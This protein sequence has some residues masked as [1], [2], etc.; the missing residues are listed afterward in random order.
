MFLEF[1]SS[2]KGWFTNISHQEN[3][4]KPVMW[5][6][7]TTITSSNRCN[8]CCTRAIW[9][10]SGPFICY[11][12]FPSQEIYFAI[13]PYFRL[14]LLLRKKSDLKNSMSKHRVK[15]SVKYST[16][17]LQSLTLFLDFGMN[18]PLSSS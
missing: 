6:L 18:F 3:S 9:Q 16:V 14:S 15:S 11:Q 8:F 5:C 1:S 17:P 7:A 4:W 12:R 10:I 13:V 2:A